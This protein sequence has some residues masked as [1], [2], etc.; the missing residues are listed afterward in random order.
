MND[1]I[2]VEGEVGKMMG[3]VK[4]MEAGWDEWQKNVKKVDVER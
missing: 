2:E 1:E 4:G 3:R